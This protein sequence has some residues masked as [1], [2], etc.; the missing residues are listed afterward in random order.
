VEYAAAAI[1]PEL[2]PS[3]A[4]EVDE[5]DDPRHNHERQGHG[6]AEQLPAEFRHVLE[7]HPVVRS[8]LWLRLIMRLNPTTSAARTHQT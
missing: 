5:G 7:V 8:S 1:P 3:F 4:L 6:I 2:Q